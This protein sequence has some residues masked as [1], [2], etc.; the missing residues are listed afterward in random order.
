[1]TIPMNKTNVENAK[2]EKERVSQDDVVKYKHDTEK[3]V[4]AEAAEE[5][6]GEKEEK[7]PPQTEQKNERRK[8]SESHL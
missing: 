2:E 4:G 6:E 1:M 7:S 8:I 5:E 3:K